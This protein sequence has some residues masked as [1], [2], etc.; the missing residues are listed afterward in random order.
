MGGEGELRR[1]PQ[2]HRAGHPRESHL[3]HCQGALEREAAFRAQNKKAGVKAGE[4]HRRG[5]YLG[6]PA[7]R[8]R[9]KGWQS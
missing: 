7:V 4:S 1:G 8:L 6:L 9:R 5:S 3:F 2:A